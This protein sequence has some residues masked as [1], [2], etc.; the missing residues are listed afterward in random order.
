MGPLAS[1][2]EIN[3]THSPHL[4]IRLRVVWLYTK[5]ARKRREGGKE[6]RREGGKEGRREGGKEGRRE[7]GKEGR[8]EGGKEGRREG[9]KEGRREGGKEGRR[10]GGKEGRR[11]GGEEGRRG[12]GE[13]G[14][15][16]GGGGRRDKHTSSLS[17]NTAECFF[18]GTPLNM[19]V[20]LSNTCCADKLS[21]LNWY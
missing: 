2:L 20:A 10:E 15:R 14:R 9:G 6:G 13:E 17:S 4:V 11:G 7:G 1:F 8:R 16:G 18:V 21:P 12:G 19:I 3:A 5:L